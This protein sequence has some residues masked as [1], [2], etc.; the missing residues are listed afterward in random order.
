MDC[1]YCL[2][3]YIP[4]ITALSYLRQTLIDNGIRELFFTSDG[5]FNY[6]EGL[7]GLDNAPFYTGRPWVWIILEYDDVIN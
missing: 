2:V 6:T 1:D 4:L 7:N 3:L 5:Y